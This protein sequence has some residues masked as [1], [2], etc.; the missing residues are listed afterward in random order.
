[1]ISGWFHLGPGRAPSLW[2]MAQND[3]L[4][5]YLDAGIAFTAMTQAR[6]EA[7][8]KDLVRA[9]EVQADQA[10][11][12]AG[13]LFD[14]SRRNTDQLIET[15]RSEVREQLSNLNVA[16]KGELAKLEERISSRTGRSSSSSGSA[17]KGAAKKS[18]KKST[19]KKSTAKKSA[20]K[21]SAAKKSS[22]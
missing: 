21:K 1:V 15:I 5:R 19:A 11:E 22:S 17:K 2:P 8:V 4:K 10:R 12:L 9:G 14:R 13:E 16:T 20:A 6:A 3:L 18:A 7:I